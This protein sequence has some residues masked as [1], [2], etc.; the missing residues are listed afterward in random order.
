MT[1]IKQL[2]QQVATLNSMIRSLDIQ[3]QS[4]D[5]TQTAYLEKKNFLA[6]K[7][8]TLQKRLSQLRS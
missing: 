4:G 3:V 7:L 5:I 2:Q 8:G 6:V 1:Q